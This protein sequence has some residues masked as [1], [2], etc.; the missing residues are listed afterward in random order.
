MAEIKKRSLNPVVAPSGIFLGKAENESNHAVWNWRSSLC[1]RPAVAEV[2]FRGD[3][4]S[5]PTQNRV[6]SHDGGQLGEGL[7][8]KGLAL[9]REDTPLVIGEEN[10]LS[11][12]LVHESLDLGVLKFDDLLLPTI[13]PVSENHHD[14][15]PWSEDGVHGIADSED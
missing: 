5:V 2:P 10:P 15:L 8:T 14:E 9:D 12:Q 4:P 3:E 6:W 7:A 13:H 1:F 11:S